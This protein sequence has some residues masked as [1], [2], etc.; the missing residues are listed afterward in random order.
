MIQGKQTGSGAIPEKMSPH[1]VIT[2]IQR[3]LRN[4]PATFEQLLGDHAVLWQNLRWD[5]SQVKLWLACSTAL[6]KCQLPNGE[7]AWALDGVSSSTSF[8][9]PDELVAL[10]QKAGRPMPLMQMLS[11]LPA[12]TVVTEPMLRAA[13]QQDERLELKGPLLK[14]AQT[15][16]GFDKGTHGN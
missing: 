14:L 10:L 8:N 4:G 7:A 11:K 16:I 1:N 6:R 15:D 2:A 9:L 12:G 13:A 5:A 3:S